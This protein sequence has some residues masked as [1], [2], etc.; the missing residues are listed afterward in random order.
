M[1]FLS[2]I[3]HKE[4][5]LRSAFTRD[6]SPTPVENALSLLRLERS[7]RLGLSWKSGGKVNNRHIGRR[8]LVLEKSFAPLSPQESTSTQQRMS[9]RNSDASLSSGIWSSI[10]SCL[11]DLIV[12]LCLVVGGCFVL[13]LVC[14]VLIAYRIVIG[15]LGLSIT[16]AVVIMHVI[17]SEK[18]KTISNNETKLESDRINAQHDVMIHAI[19]QQHD[20]EKVRITTSAQQAL[21]QQ[22][23]RTGQYLILD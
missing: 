8:G 13:S 23:A 6:S 1:I 7:L 10:F 9:R 19:D 22:Y 15:W 17:S 14:R 3:R 12:T 18:D 21:M 4:R 16:V 11:S 2:R 20:L 5:K